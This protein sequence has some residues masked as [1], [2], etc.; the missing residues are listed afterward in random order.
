MATTLTREAL[1]KSATP[2]YVEQI[3][4]NGLVARIRSITEDEKSAYESIVYDA[5]GKFQ[6]ARLKLRRRKLI[7]LCLVDDAGV[8]LY[9]AQELPSMKMDGGIA[10]QLFDAMVKHCGLDAGGE[11]VT[12]AKNDSEPITGSDSPSVSA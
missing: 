5:E 9:T 2:R 4:S 6:V 11:N 10:S 12:A 8:N 1:T 3:L 7:Q